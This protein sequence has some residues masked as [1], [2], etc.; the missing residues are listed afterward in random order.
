MNT[1][2]Q[3]LRDNGYTETSPGV[4]EKTPAVG[5][6]R[7]AVTEPNVGR[8]AKDASGETRGKGGVV[9]S[10]ARPQRRRKVGRLQLIA[11]RNRLLDDDNLAASYKH[12]RD[13]IADSLIP[14]LAPGAADGWFR[15]E[16]GQVGTTGE[17]GTIVMVM[18]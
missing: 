14:G 2:R 7:P 4:W 15:W 10:D 8:P 12:L 6:L 3:T 18:I 5:V 11:L 9:K 17:E 16:Y 1:T 13:A